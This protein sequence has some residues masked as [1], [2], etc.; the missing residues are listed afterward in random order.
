[1]S[2]SIPGGWSVVDAADGDYD[3]VAGRVVWNL[4]PVGGGASLD[5]QLDL[6]APATSPIDGGLDVEATFASWLEVSGS[7]TSGPS[8]TVLVAPAV[9]VEHSTLGRVS[10]LTLAP[11]Y[12]PEDTALLDVPALRHDPRPL[13]AP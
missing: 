3:R 6:Q 8:A 5:R 7:I 13:P 11:R 2:V 10:E 4:D 12:S 9:E 1:M